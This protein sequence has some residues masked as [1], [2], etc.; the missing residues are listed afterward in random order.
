M[1]PGGR[2][3]RGCILK[4][5]Y[6]Y[7]MSYTPFISFVLS[8]LHHLPWS[9]SSPLVS[10]LYPVLTTLQPSSQHHLLPT[11]FSLL[12]PSGWPAPTTTFSFSVSELW[13]WPKK[14]YPVMETEGTT[15]MLCPTLAGSPKS[16]LLLLLHP[17]PGTL[18]FH[19]NNPKPSILFSYP[20]PISYLI[21]TLTCPEPFLPMAQGHVLPTAP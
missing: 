17:H 9:L 12:E 5:N 13:I 1:D 14:H 21:C 2:V 10:L 16:W 4:V 6:N 18:P 20:T 11:L 8:F 15:Q 3:L 7:P 19:S